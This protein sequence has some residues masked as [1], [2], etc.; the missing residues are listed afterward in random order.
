MGNCDLSCIAAA[1]QQGMLS[2]GHVRPLPRSANMARVFRASGF[3]AGAL[4][5]CRHEDSGCHQDTTLLQ[6][7]T[8]VDAAVQMV[9]TP[10]DKMA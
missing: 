6:A 9:G 8:A 2:G 4:E 10:C 3:E 1:L 5:V 7:G